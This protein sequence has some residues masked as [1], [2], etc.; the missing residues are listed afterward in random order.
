M[1]ELSGMAKILILF[2]VAMAKI[3]KMTDITEI[4]RKAEIPDFK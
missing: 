3:P 2:V 4:A 1:I